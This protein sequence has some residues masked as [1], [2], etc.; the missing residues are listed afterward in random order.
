MKIDNGDF[1]PEDIKIYEC[2]D[3]KLDKILND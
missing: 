3:S 1:E 2:R